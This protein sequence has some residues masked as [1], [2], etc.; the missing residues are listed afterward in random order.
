MIDSAASH[1]IVSDQNL[2]FHFDYYKE[3]LLVKTAE[4]DAVLYSSGEGYFPLFV[5]AGKIK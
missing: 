3:P 5:L 1:N 2:L 4:K